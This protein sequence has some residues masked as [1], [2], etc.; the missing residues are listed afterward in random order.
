M[1]FNDEDFLIVNDV[2]ME[3]AKDQSWNYLLA[4]S[5]TS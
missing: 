1:Y 5:V 4:Y 2:M 3:Y